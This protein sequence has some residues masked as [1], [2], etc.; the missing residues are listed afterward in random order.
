MPFS[1]QFLKSMCIAGGL[2][3]LLG[4]K[5]NQLFAKVLVFL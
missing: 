5:K 3:F 2:F 1:G 4:G